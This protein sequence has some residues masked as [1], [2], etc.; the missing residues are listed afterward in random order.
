MAAMFNLRRS[1][2]L[3]FA[4]V[5]VLEA[6]DVVLAE[7]RA[8][9]HLDDVQRDLAGILDAVL[10]A[11]RNVGRLI[12]LEQ[13]RLLAARDARSAGDY[14]PMLGAMMM[15]LQRH[16]GAGLDREALHL[17]AIAVV[18]AV[19][20]APGPKHFAMQGSFIAPLLFQ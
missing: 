13:E 4:A 2:C 3:A 7:I 9:L 14:D 19:V 11:E 6:H 20:A 17:E 12:L 16:R 10:R 5:A 18:D 1:T 8:G 15:H